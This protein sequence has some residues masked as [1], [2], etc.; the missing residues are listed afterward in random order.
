MLQQQRETELVE[1]CGKAV[2]TPSPSGQES[3][4][5]DI[6]AAAMGRLGFDSVERDRLGNVVGTIDGGNPGATVLFEGHMDH[7]DIGDRDAWSREPFGAEEVDGRIYGRGTSDMKGSLTAMICAAAFLREDL[8]NT[9]PGRLCVAGS[10]HEECFEG[11][12]SREISAAVE[13]DFVVIGEPS[14]LSL[15]I[16]Q[17]GRAEVVLETA[18]VNAH[19]SSPEKGI[20]AVRTMAALLVEMEHGYDAPE[21]P[22]LGKGIL[23]P[24]DICSAPYP[25]AS[26]LPHHCRVTFDRR[27]LPGENRE[28]VLADIREIIDR[29]SAERPELNATASIAVGRDRCYTGAALEAERFAPAWQFHEGDPVVTAALQGLRDQGQ[30]PAIGHYAFCT[31]GSHYAGERM[32]PTV[33]YGPSPETMAHVKDEYIEREQ[34]KQACCGFYGIA[35]RLLALS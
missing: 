28:A 24:T 17:R 10:V 16:G 20:N 21:H 23:E 6:V 18:G 1:L 4:V 34:L 22:L 19:S 11:V 9:L 31:N 12:A 25:G 15:K 14:G 32:I 35:R 30:E 13:P 8:G 27:L 5:A 29:L 2:R 7:V 3:A 33:G 26:V